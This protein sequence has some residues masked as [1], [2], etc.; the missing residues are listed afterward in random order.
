VAVFFFSIFHCFVCVFIFLQG[1][2]A[3]FLCCIFLF[4]LLFCRVCEFLFFSLVA[5]PLHV[6]TCTRL[7][8]VCF[9]FFFSLGA[10]SFCCCFFFFF[11]VVVD[12]W[13]CKR[14]HVFSPR[15]LTQ[16]APPPP[17]SSPASSKTSL[18]LCSDSATSVEVW[19]VTSRSF[20]L[21]R[22]IPRFSVSFFFYERFRLSVRALVVSVL[23]LRLILFFLSFAS[24]SRLIA[25]ND[26]TDSYIYT[27]IIIIITLQRSGPHI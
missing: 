20:F 17:S 14:T 1:F 16:L 8:R 15:V 21:Y 19:V 12:E 24:L 3:L 25:L 18:N 10:A 26:I 23:L 7:L 5:L 2:N 11:A 22:Y 6:P 27:S 9:V 4:S 13:V